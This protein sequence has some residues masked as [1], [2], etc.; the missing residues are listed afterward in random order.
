MGIGLK[1]L[2]E[3]EVIMNQG[4]NLGSQIGRWIIL[5]ALVA[6]LGALLLTMRPVGAQDAPPLIPNAETEFTYVEEGTGPVTTYRAT[7]PEGKKIFW[8]LEGADAADFK[9]DGGVLSFK[10]PPNYENPTDRDEDPVAAD[11]QRAGDNIYRV[12]VRFGAGGEDGMPGDDDYDGDDL[13]KL[14]LTIT[15]TNLDEEGGVSI[16]SLQ[17]QVGTE[18]TATVFDR[19]GVAGVGSWQWARSDSMNGTFEPIPERSSDR[20]YRPTIDDLGKYLRVT[21]RYRD[22]VSG[23]DIREKATV[24]ANSVRKDNVTSNDPPKFPDQRTLGVSPLGDETYARVATERFIHERS[25]AGTRV[26]APVTAFDDATAIDLLTYSLADG[27]EAVHDGHASN[28]SIDERTGQITLSARGA[29]A[30]NAEAD[31]DQPGNPGTPYSVTVRAIDGD[32]HRQDILVRIWVVDVNE[33]PG[34][35][36]G[37]REMSH[38]EADRNTS[39]ALV[40]DTDLDS[41][42]ITDGTDDAVY[43]ARDPEDG[44]NNLTWSLEGDDGWLFAITEGQATTGTPAMATATLSFKTRAQ[45]AATHPNSVVL[46]DYPYFPD[47]DKPRDA[48]KDNVYEVTLVVTDPLGKRGTYNVTVKVINSTEDNRPGKVTIL[49]RQPEVAI[50]LDTMFDDPDKPT[51]EVKYQWYRLATDNQTQTTRCAAYNPHSTTDPAATVRGFLASDAFDSGQPWADWERISGATSARYTPGYDEDSG[52]SVVVADNV[53]TWTGGDIDVVITTALDGEKS[54]AWDNPRCLRV[55]VTYRDDVDRTNPDPDDLDTGVDETLEGTY[56]GSEYPVKRLDEENDAPRFTT[57]GLYTG[58][59]AST[60][61]AE[62]REDTTHAVIGGDNPNPNT[63]QITEAE[64]AV[65][66]FEDTESPANVLEDDPTNDTLTYSLSGTDAK[67][68]VIVGSVQHPES[69]DSDGDDTDASPV[70]EAGSLFIRDTDGLDFERRKTYQ[71]TITATDPSGEK[72]SVTVN[73]IITNLNEEPDWVK[74]P[75]RPDHEEND[76]SVVATY[77]AK[78]PEGSG[79][80]YSLVDDAT[81]LLDIADADIADRGLFTINL[82]DGTLSFKSPANYEKPG[83]GLA[84]NGDRTAATDNMYKVAVKAEVVDSPALATPHATYRKVTV[85]V[86]NVN[87]APEFPRT[88]DT[89]EIKE[90]ADDPQKEQPATEEPLYL[91]NRG[92]GI[93]GANL[94]AAPDLDVGVPVVAADDDS[95]GN[96]A[97]GPYSPENARD[98]I[99]GLTYTLSGADASHFVI[100]PATGQILTLEKLN[101]E[102]KNEYKVTVKATDPMGE[103]DSIPITIEVTDVEEVPV[104]EALVL[105]GSDF[106]SYEENGTDAVGEYEVGSFG[107]ATA[108]PTWT[109]EGT[110]A[111]DF[112]LTGTGSTRMLEFTSAPDYDNPTGGA[113]DDSN[114]Y[115]VT[116]KVTDPSDSQIVDTL[117]VR[118]DVT[119]LDELGALSGDNSLTQ[120]ENGTDAVGAYR[121]TGTAADT[122]NWSLGGADADQF[123]L[124]GS[125]PTRMLKFRSAPDYE[126]PMGGAAD[127][128]N[129]YMV[130]VQAEAGGEMEMVE[131]TVRV[132]NVDELGTLGGPTS[133][134]TD[135]GAMDVLGTYTLTGIADDTADWSLDGD[136]AGQFMLDGTGMSRM[137]SFISAPDYEAPMGGAADD[138]NTYMVTVMASASGEMEMVEATV[139]VNNVEEDGTVTLT[140]AL[141]SVGNAI[142]ASVEDAD[143]VS[144]ESWQWAKHAATADDSCPLRTPPTGWT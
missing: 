135:E 41:V 121:L 129:T 31:T 55:V 133:A 36:G 21:A 128:S 12:T 78:D 138:S 97:V 85:I 4:T 35:T 6:L 112:T 104:A 44:E 94:P 103:S 67:H 42:G 82:L 123:M 86:R 33:S 80:N 48:N 113:N 56:M 101:Y 11:P 5:A 39:P 137:L 106:H 18:L 127:D 34:I 120:A 74:A 136:D 98:R 37:A 15:V 89:L 54:Y 66:L 73:V 77:E 124:E 29:R 2:F 47:F 62:R 10:S 20:T 93:P 26:G 65:D 109:L 71:V 23:A 99:D 50:A 40:I 57:D 22:N 45:L 88:T 3:K 107:G 84:D 28:F 92:V 13:G 53:A 102:I 19:D 142:A 114:T 115:E 16:S 81:D 32:G 144:S 108:S 64:A 96:F 122:A 139:T 132:T 25:T 61:R 24:S 7:D 111:G 117:N 69:F 125:G 58:T 1:F 72:D 105:R 90:N 83:D 52:G 79:I 143:I 49:N 110:D 8:T 51:R 70:T 126:T 75:G 60:Y 91:L 118:V 119:D 30:L 100:V 14:D 63:V 46:S 130:T 59:D 87:E 140:P 9:I 27:P 43:M 141:P 116:I 68:F 17:P 95:T 131:V 38:Y 76:A 134:S